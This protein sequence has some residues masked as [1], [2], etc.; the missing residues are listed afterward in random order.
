M[1]RMHSVTLM[2]GQ[3]IG[4]EVMEATKRVL[5]ATGLR[6]D[7][8]VQPIGNDVGGL[9]QAAIDSLVR[10]KVGLKGPTETPTDDDKTRSINVA[11]RQRF[12]LFANVRPIRTMPGV[13][14]RFSDVKIDIRIFRENLEDLYAGDGYMEDDGETAVSLARI[15]RMG[16]ERIAH[17]AFQWACDNGRKRVTIVH[18]ANTVKPAYSFFLKVAREVALIYPEVACDDIIV[19][20][21]AQ[22][23]VIRPERFDVLLLPNL[24]GD[25]ASDLC[26]GLVGGLGFAPGANI[27]PD[28]A[29]FEAVHGTAPDIAGK[30]IANPTSLILSAA[31]ML[32]HLGEMDAANRIRE[33]VDA[34]LLEGTQ[35]TADAG[36]ATSVGTRDF[37]N[38]VIHAMLVPEP[39]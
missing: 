29:I 5:R 20:N 37:T 3:G 35:V 7:F 22:Q 27:G 26:A 24:F 10:T 9:P 2:P 12:G 14:T 23:M 8:D 31:M 17:A 18:K 19:D 38:A 21:F 39:V 6:F 13:K 1:K 30:G 16:V 25:I 32:D 33:A 28:C 36:R 34:V 11:L 15:T 4:P